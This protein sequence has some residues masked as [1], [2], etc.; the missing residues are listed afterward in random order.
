MTT[1]HEGQRLK[2]LIEN[3]DI[4]LKHIVEKLGYSNYE[5]LYYYYDKAQIK[6]STLDRFCEVLN[7][8]V[9]TFYNTVKKIDNYTN[10]VAKEDASTTY[11]TSK[12]QGKNLLSLLENRGITK[13]HF[14]KQLNISRPTLDSYFDEKELPL[15]V[16]LEV[17][18][19]LQTPV[20]NIKGIGA[21]EKSFEKDIYLLLHD[22]NTK[23][24]NLLS[25]KH[26]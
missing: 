4:K 9:D 13:T 19:V 3:Q 8:S 18:H 12:H 11:T 17:A 20:A 22:I 24:D 6:R 14:A 15:H 10:N 1:I 21:G 2:Y 5:R 7:I 25:A 23:L 16:L 26:F